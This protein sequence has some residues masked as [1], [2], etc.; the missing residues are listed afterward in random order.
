RPYQAVLIPSCQTLSSR[1][2]RALKSLKGT[3]IGVLNPAPY[4]LDGLGGEKAF[5][6]EDFLSSRRVRRINDEDELELFLSRA[7]RRRVRAYERELN[8]P[9]RSTAI[10]L[11]ERG[12]E[13]RIWMAELSGRGKKLLIEIESEVRLDLDHWHADGM[14]YAE[15][16]LK[17]YG[18]AEIC[19]EGEGD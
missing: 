16:R 18:M 10:F 3:G 14:T 8:Y 7:V 2:L 11:G 12:R 6:L 19:F 4:L 13:G 9:S 17:P 1:A 5:E 15:V